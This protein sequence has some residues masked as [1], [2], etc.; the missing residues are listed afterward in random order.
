M[1]LKSEVKALLQAFANNPVPP[2]EKLP[3][4]EAR[5]GYEQS[6]KLM[7][8]AEKLAITEDQKIRGFNEEIDIRIYTPEE[9]GESQLPAI[10]YYHGGGWVIGN[11]E[12]HD[13]LCHTMSNEAKCI[14]IS[15]DYSLAPES[16][17]P[18]AVEDAYLAAKW[19]FENAAELNIDETFIA[20]AG[21][22]AGGNLAAVVSYLEVES[23]TPSI[24]YQMLFYPS[25]GFEYTP[26]YEK[27]GEGYYLT[28][29]TMNWFR[30]QYLNSP[31][32][33]QNPL[34]APMLIPD[35]ITAQLPPT[36][37]MTAELDP[38]SDGGEHFAMKL[39]NAGVDTEYVCV[40]GMLHG[41][42][43]M[44]EFLPDGKKAIKDAAEAF[45]NRSSLKPVE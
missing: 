25:T 19:V 2:L 18:V 11:I 39:K 37:I 33:T 14:V 44:T 21:D 12:T 6:S 42:L 9:I 30:E 40:P 4:E 43:G 41:F 26:S 32:D 35:D 15:V 45:K 27:Y 5:K 17:F 24:A 23:Q 7:S 1:P 36:C 16:K 38:L 8:K 34:A 28:K 20:V 3:L 29:S 13:A 10:V 31:E 22:S